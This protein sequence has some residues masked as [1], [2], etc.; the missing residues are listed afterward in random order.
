MTEKPTAQKACRGYPPE[1]WSWSSYHN[2]ALDRE[3]VA[4]CPLQ[5]DYVTLPEGY[6]A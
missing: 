3:T 2:F 6:R 5:I 1:D 4:A